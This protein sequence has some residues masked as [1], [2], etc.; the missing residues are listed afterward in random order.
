MGHASKLQTP[1]QGA[2]PSTVVADES[3]GVRPRPE[4]VGK[5][6]ILKPETKS[7]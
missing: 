3:G 4:I 2:N 6:R 5:N 1:G 7:G